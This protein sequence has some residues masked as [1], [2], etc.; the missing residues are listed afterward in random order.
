MSSRE[1][2]TDIV[3]GILDRYRQWSF[4]QVFEVRFVQMSSRNL[5]GVLNRHRQGSFEHISSWE[6][7]KDVVKAG[8]NRVQSSTFLHAVFF[9]R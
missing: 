2:W 7:W 1:F 9:F 6:F 4:G 5:K 8:L 3:M